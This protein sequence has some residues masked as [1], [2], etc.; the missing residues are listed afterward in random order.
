MTSHWIPINE[1]ARFAASTYAGSNFG[2][3]VS[4]PLSGWLC[5]LEFMDG[6]PLSF[7]LFGALGLVWCFFWFT[8]VY[9]TPATHPRISH[10]ERNYIEYSLKTRESNLQI[11]KVNESVPWKSILTSPPMWGLIVTQCGQS[12]AFYTQLTEIPTYMS[13]ILHYNIEESAFLT[14]LPHLTTWVFAISAASMADYLLTKGH[15]SLKNSYRLWNTVSS[16][17]PSL[18][19]CAVVWAGCDKIWVMIML[20]GLGSFAGA[21][22]P[23]NQ[24]NHIVLSPRFGST[25]YALGLVIE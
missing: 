20:A 16:V 21:C 11:V 9:N 15:I 3:I 13:R 5:S 19:L 4:L 25:M 8:L 18:G 14:A 23:G 24:L 7:Y 17:I 10:D 22:Y 1:R 12:W 6:W 2:T